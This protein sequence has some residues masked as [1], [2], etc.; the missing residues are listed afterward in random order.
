MKE[1]GIEYDFSGYQGKVDSQMADKPA[2]SKRKPSAEATE[3]PK[4]KKSKK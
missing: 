1:L 4:K 3:K 2:F